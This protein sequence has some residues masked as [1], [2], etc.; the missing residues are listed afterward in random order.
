MKMI[1]HF[2]RNTRGFSLIEVIIIITISSLAFAAIFTYFGT[3]ITD[4]SAPIRQLAGSME[5]KQTAERITEAFRQDTTADLNLLKNSLTTTPEQFGS[6]YTV[7]TNQFIKFVSNN[8]TAIVSPDPEDLLKV[9][10]EHAASS[11]TLTLL[12][13]KE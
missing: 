8:D 11:E 2:F 7:V 10:I 4:S 3:V 12:F 1:P 9:K 6:N 5:L 13:H